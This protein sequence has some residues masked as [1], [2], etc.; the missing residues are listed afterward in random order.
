[1][2]LLEEIQMRLD[3]LHLIYE[4]IWQKRH[5]LEDLQTVEDAQAEY[6]ALTAKEEGRLADFKRRKHVLEEEK[7]NLTIPEFDAEIV[8]FPIKASGRRQ[9]VRQKVQA[10][11]KAGGSDKIE[12]RHYLKKFVN[13]WAYSWHLDATVLGHVNRIADDVKCPLGEALILLGW[14]IF[15]D[16]TR[17]HESPEN[18]LRRIIEW[19]NALSEYEEIL[20]SQIDTLE[21]RFQSW[22]P[23]WERW[24]A[25][26]Q[27]KQA[28]ADW[29]TFILASCN[30]KQEQIASLEREISH[31]SE[32]ISQL[33]AYLRGMEGTIP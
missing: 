9:P 5:R 32:E 14:E 2:N 7:R 3:S 18:H 4:N 25:R 27:S 12:A 15:E 23:I 31:L 24:R 28:I 20:T 26:E 21:A 30:A 33:K 6:E 29:N 8:L 11:K 22:L 10:S 13:R 16:R 1:M 17:T 19:G